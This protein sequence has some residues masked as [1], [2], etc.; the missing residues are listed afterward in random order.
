MGFNLITAASQAAQD[1]GNAATDIVHGVGEALSTVLGVVYVLNLNNPLIS[2]FAVALQSGFN[3][4]KL[5]GALQDDWNRIS[6]LDQI[7]GAIVD[8]DYIKAWNL[9]T[10]NGHDL[11]TLLNV[12]T[13][14]AEATLKDLTNLPQQPHMARNYAGQ[15]AQYK[16]GGG[17]LRA[18][19]QL[20]YD[21]GDYTT[22]DAAIVAWGD[23]LAVSPLGATLALGSAES[24]KDAR[25]LMHLA[26]SLEAAAL[27]SDTIAEWD[28]SHWGNTSMLTGLAAT[29]RE[30]VTDIL[31]AIPTTSYHLLGMSTI[32]AS[33]MAALA[34]LNQSIPKLSLWAQ[35]VADIKKVFSP[36]M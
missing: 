10:N 32:A 21:N 26:T 5:W 29:A 17:D 20:A 4:S 30:K 18:L 13:E 15:L 8:G 31:T 28:A 11:N 16:A 27:D 6:Q 2:E 25:V 7:P 12:S 24:T 3:P 22:G 35:F 1:I 9:I 19:A 33:D 34:H 23:S 36:L 14:T